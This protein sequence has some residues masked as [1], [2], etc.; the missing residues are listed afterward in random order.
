MTHSSQ[1]ADRADR[2]ANLAYDFDSR[3]KRRIERC[4]LCGSDQFVFLNTHDRYGFKSPA[5]SCM[6]CSLTVLNPVMTADAYGDFYANVYRPLV[7]AYHGRLI[8]AETIQDEQREYAGA[9]GDLLEPAFRTREMKT[10]LDIGGSTG[11]VAVD[12]AKRFSLEATVLDP[13]ADELDWAGKFGVET[14]SG[15][16]E[17][18]EPGS[19]RFD[20]IV[21]CQTVDHLAD[22]SGTLAKIA[23][24]LS[25]KG[26]FFVDIVDFR[27]AY[28][29]N[30]GPSGAIKIDHPYYLTELTMEVML[31]NAG[32]RIEKKSFAADGLHIGYLCSG[33]APTGNSLPDPED[34]RRHFREIRFVQNARP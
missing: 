23:T 25:P 1:T 32:F 19:R 5:S 3:D 34:V 13:A 22:V 14:I 7:S 16:V 29:R 15:F 33:G 26:L 4:E 20:L 2:I 31:A 27:A 17:D 8:D 30:K 11:I 12:L 10:L 28:L 9:L 6:V 24:L 18:Y 21:L